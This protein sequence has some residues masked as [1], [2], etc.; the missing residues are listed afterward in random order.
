MVH[1]LMMG[2]RTDGERATFHN[3]KGSLGAGGHPPGGK[4]TRPT[5][6]PIP[7]L[8]SRGDSDFTL[9]TPLT[10]RTGLLSQRLARAKFVSFR[11]RFS[12]RHWGRGPEGSRGLGLR[13]RPIPSTHL[14]L[15]VV[16]RGASPARAALPAVLREA[17]FVRGGGGANKRIE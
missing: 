9:R 12:T 17:F 15:L 1:R 6:P 7:P 8:N 11:R 3:D 5:A 16:L 10:T 2:K 4:K 14:S 13:A